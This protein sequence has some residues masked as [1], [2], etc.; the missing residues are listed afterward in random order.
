M[1]FWDKKSLDLLAKKSVMAKI[2]RV[3]LTEEQQCELEKIVN[4]SIGKEVRTRWSY[5]L[6]ASDENGDLKWNKK[7]VDWQFANKDARIKLKRLYPSYLS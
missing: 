7:G 5:A 3:T 4:S 6:L 1:T 2:Y